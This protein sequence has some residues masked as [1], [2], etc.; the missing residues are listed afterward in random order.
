MVSLLGHEVLL[1]PRCTKKRYSRWGMAR[2]LDEEI[3]ITCFQHVFNYL[4]L[5]TWNSDEVCNIY[6]SLPWGQQL[7][8]EVRDSLDFV[9]T[10][11]FQKH[12]GFL[13]TLPRCLK[14]ARWLLDFAATFFRRERMHDK[15]TSLKLRFF[16]ERKELCTLKNR[17][18]DGVFSAHTAWRPSRHFT[19]HSS[20]TIRQSKKLKTL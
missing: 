11:L 19:N 9:N 13:H 18:V 5:K 20:S 17:S 14:R 4:L 16:S 3:A 15:K 7:M 10:N 8:T 2:K 6:L 12:R 1:T